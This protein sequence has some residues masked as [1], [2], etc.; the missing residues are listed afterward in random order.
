MTTFDYEEW[1]MLY[2][3]VEEQAER[4]IDKA[5]NADGQEQYFTALEN[6][7]GYAALLKKISK[8]ATERFPPVP[9]KETIQ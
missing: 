9:G 8:M 5:Q 6:A 3:A 1:P 2:A 4:L 7:A